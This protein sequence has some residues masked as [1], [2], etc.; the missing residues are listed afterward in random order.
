MPALKL[1]PDGTSH[2]HEYV[3]MSP[4]QYKCAHP[5]CSHYTRREI[6]I[7]KESLCSVCHTERILLDWESLRRAGPRCLNCANTN[8]AKRK[9]QTKQQLEELGIL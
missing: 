2:I 9:R 4:N 5:S 7:G 8:E 3:R 6:L 1:N